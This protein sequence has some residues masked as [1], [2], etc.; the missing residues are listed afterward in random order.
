MN[1]GAHLSIAG[2]I[3]NA[4]LKAG[5]KGLSSLQIFTGSP[6]SWR[7]INISQEQKDEF[8]TVIKKANINP[9]FIHAKY[10]T[11]PSSDKKE[12]Q[13]K[14]TKSLINDLNIAKEI[15]ALG[16]IFHP[17]LENSK[18]LL[19]NIT[20]ILENSSNKQ[21]ILENSAQMDIKDLGKIF[22]TINSKRLTFCLDTAH[23][24]ES[25]YNL[26]DKKALKEFISFI[27][28]N[29]GLK[30]LVV[31][32]LNNSK[33]AFN[34]KH[35]VHADLKNGLIEKNVFKFFINHS[36]MKNLPFILETPSLKS[37][38]WRKTEENI[39]FLKSLEKEN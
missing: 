30:K 1:I 34:S 11:N 13:E 5:K 16:V 36:K 15:G 38:S 24:F 23:A 17:K 32:H 7:T 2:G 35:D 29:I 19:K 33:T 27:Q 39:N 28:K 31:I 12:L 26:N 6:R 3:K 10:L 4:A 8:K 18:I 9:V 14:S 20:T 37:K 21:L 22:K 25:G